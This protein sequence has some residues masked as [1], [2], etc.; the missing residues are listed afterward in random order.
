MEDIFLMAKFVLLILVAILFLIIAV[1]LPIH[2]ALSL[3]KNK[4]LGFIVPVIYGSLMSALFYWAW[5]TLFQDDF[6]RLLQ[7]DLRGIFLLVVIPPELMYIITYY[8]CRL[9]AED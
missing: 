1:S 4:L 5:I 9:K 6:S 8:I 7:I 2:I 3:S